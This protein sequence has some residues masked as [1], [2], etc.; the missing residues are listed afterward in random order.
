MNSSQ[1]LRARIVLGGII[2]VA[3]GLAIVLYS[4]QITRGESYSAKAN[5]QY[6]RPGTKIFDRGTIFMSGKD[7][8]H[9]AAATLTSSYSISMT[10]KLVVDV[11]G[12]YEALTH[13]MDIDKADFLLKASLKDDPY[14][15]IAQKVDETIASSIRSLALTGIHVTKESRRSYPGNETAAHAIGII[16]ENSAGEVE[17]KYGLE[18]T[19]NAILVRPN[20]GYNVSLFAQLLSGTGIETDNTD[21]YGNLVTTLEPTVQAYLEKILL[22]TNATWKSDEIGG[23]I[24]DPKTGEIIAAASLPTFNPND[25]S[26]IKNTAVLT[27][28]LVEHVYEMGSIMKPLTVAVGLDTDVITT[29]ST[30][31]D[32]G[33]MTLSGKKISNFDGKARGVVKVQEILSQSLNVGAAT[34]ALKIGAKNFTK[35]FYA[36]GFGEK[37]GIDQP[38]EA[39]GINNLKSGRDIEIATAAYGQGIAVSPIEMTRGLAVLANGGLLIKPHFGKQIEYIDG[40]KKILYFGVPS[41]VLKQESAEKVTRMLVKVVDESLRGGALKLEKY[42]VAAK[43]GTAQI[44]DPVSKKYYD[45]RYLHSFFGYFPA[46]DAKFLVFLYQKHPK[47]AQYAS[48]TLTEPFHDLTKFLIDYYN[49]V[50]DR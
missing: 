47:D 30:Y 43:T 5:K 32:T 39:T 6:I 19:Y 16:G 46:Y 27:N 13:Y 38:N 36:I 34:V 42:S 3:L 37:T 4:V 9:P 7:D 12:S 18:R 41:R 48:E 14:E 2:V 1:R 26:K 35:Y 8:A 20:S 31:D 40:T 44:P 25:L 49:V 21:L 10:P 15:E 33:T 50:P 28:P 22:K 17:G 29:N 23:I 45:D 11:E 24:I